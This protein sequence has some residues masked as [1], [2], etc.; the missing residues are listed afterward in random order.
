MKMI[1]SLLI[2]IMAG[3]IIMVHS[4]EFEV[5]G[6][7]NYIGKLAY[8][9]Y[10]FRIWDMPPHTPG[11]SRLL[12][13]RITQEAALPPIPP[14]GAKEFV[15]LASLFLR[16]RLILG[17]ITRWDDEPSRHRLDFKSSKHFVDIDIVCGETETIAS[18]TNL[19]E[20]SAWLP[21]VDNLEKATRDKFTLAARFY[22]QALEMIEATTDMAYLNLV[23]A[24][25]T[26]CGDTDIGN[27]KLTDVDDGLANAVVR[28]N[29]QD[30]RKDIEE[31]IIKRE[32]FIKR[33]FVEFI[34]Q[35]ID[36]SFWTYRRR[37][38]E[39][40][41]VKPEDLDRLLKNIYDQRSR[42]LHSGEPFPEYIYMSQ[43]LT[44]I[45][46]L[47]YNKSYTIGRTYMEEIPFGDKI[48]VGNRE[49]TPEEY[50]PYPHFFE[51]LVNHVLKNYLKTNQ[52]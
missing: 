36:D 7:A 15:S 12:C 40:I 1:E 27:I 13:L 49:W 28:V 51:R 41:R 3:G 14:T 6:D 8:G 37:P 47:E 18:E 46:H 26:L 20:L 16:K 21:L 10:Y 19:D 33:R 32:R 50:I 30:L 39:N 48:M 35:H 34:K 24:V 5:I 52:K 44:D 29:P 2:S 17:P 22:Q 23:S 38:Q 25:E 42:T 11:E 31:R 43:Q 9:P 45:S 4:Y